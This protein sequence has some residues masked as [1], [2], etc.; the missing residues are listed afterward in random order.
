MRVCCAAFKRSTFPLFSQRTSQAPARPASSSHLSTSSSLADGG[1]RR[2]DP[3]LATLPSRA[4]TVGAVDVMMADRDPAHFALEPAEPA[5]QLRRRSKFSF[6]SDP[7]D[8]PLHDGMSV[9]VVPNNTPKPLLPMWASSLTSPQLGKQRLLVENWISVDMLE[10]LPEEHVSEFI[11]WLRE[12]LSCDTRAPLLRQLEENVQFYLGSRYARGLIARRP[13]S[14]G[15]VI[16]TIPFFGLPHVDNATTSIAPG[17]EAPFGLVL[18]SET[19]ERHSLAAKRRRVPSFVNVEALISAQKSFF[20]PVPHSLF[21]DQVY[22]ALLLACERAEGARSPLYPYLR[23]LKTFDDDF[24]REIHRDVLEPPIYL[25]Y[26][27]HCGRF[28]HFLR[29]I[30][31]RWVEDYEVASRMEA[32]S[33]PPAER[34]ATD[35]AKLAM[36]QT[37]A[38][39]SSASFSRLPPPSFE[40]LIWAFR[41]VLSRQRLLPLRHDVAQFEGVCTAKKRMQKERDIWTR[42]VTRVKWGVLDR[43]FGVVDHARVHVNDFDPRAIA[44]VV[45]V[46]DMLHPPPN[47]AANTNVSMEVLPTSV[48]GAAEDRRR[49]PRAGAVGAV[50]RASTDIEEGDALTSMFPKCYSVS[51]TLYRFGFLPLRGR[52]DD[53]TAHSSGAEKY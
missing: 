5:P 28:S 42:I 30:H 21:V 14:A 37:T 44:T 12:R 16:L 46:L 41:I 2:R 19:L 20:D 17:L 24:I 18:N 48:A 27:D 45:P 13:F 9:N 31:Q 43:V 51:Y 15:D 25:E 33:L 4:K 38:H 35:V 53:M 23:L 8:R 7:H 39:H 47:G 1:E 52:V 36:G 40:E 29:L 11:A 50:V 3:P 22:C 49:D 32:A 34:A 10:T 6:F 26:S